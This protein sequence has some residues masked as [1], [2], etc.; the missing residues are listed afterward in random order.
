M[1]TLTIQANDPEEMKLQLL[2][3]L[4]CMKG[5]SFSDNSNK[6]I[7]TSTVDASKV[8]A[9]IPEIPVEEPPLAAVPVDEPTK[10]ATEEIEAPAE[11]LKKYTLED[12]RSVL[13]DMR[14]R[15][16]AVAVKTMLKTFGAENVMALKEED[17]ARVIDMAQ[18]EV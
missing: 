18:T 14:D 5:I 3:I 7:D 8:E 4:S 11:A 10:A 13:K 1:Y 6:P 17:Y 15:K 16:G 12:V 2:G 9:T